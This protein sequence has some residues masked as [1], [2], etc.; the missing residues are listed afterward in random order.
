MILRYKGYYGSV[1]Q[2]QGIYWGKLLMISDPVTY[3]GET[4]EELIKEFPLAVD[5][6]LRT[7]VEV[8]KIPEKPMIMDV[9]RS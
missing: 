3:E 5:D 8:G 6:Y 7:C 4:E 1:N 2:E 9:G